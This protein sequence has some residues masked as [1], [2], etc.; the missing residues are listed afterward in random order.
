MPQSMV[1]ELTSQSKECYD[2]ILY[3]VMQVFV[4]TL[5]V[6]FLFPKKGWVI[7]F[8]ISYVIFALFLNPKLSQLCVKHLQSPQDS[9]RDWVKLFEFFCK[10]SNNFFLM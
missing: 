5:L 9:L 8:L 7:C 1:G 2:E 4:V 10:Q 3:K 6:L